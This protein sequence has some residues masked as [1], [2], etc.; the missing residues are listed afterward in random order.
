VCSLG[1]LVGVVVASSVHAAWEIKLPSEYDPCSTSLQ[2]VVP[3]VMLTSVHRSAHILTGTCSSD[4]NVV[5][6]SRLLVTSATHMCVAES[7]HKATLER[8]L[9]LHAGQ[10]R[11]QR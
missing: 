9:Q 5:N 6:W 4:S 2:I 7:G 11:G 8:T 3:L 1:T 10:H